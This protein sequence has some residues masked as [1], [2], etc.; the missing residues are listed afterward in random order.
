MMTIIIIII[1]IVSLSKSLKMI[2]NSQNKNLWNLGMKVVII[3]ETYN[4]FLP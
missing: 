3:L 4:I 2:I 1:I